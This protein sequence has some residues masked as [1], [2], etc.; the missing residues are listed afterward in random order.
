MINLR[1]L[2]ILGVFLVNAGFLHAQTPPRAGR[3]TQYQTGTDPC[4]DL[5]GD[6][7]FACVVANNSATGGGSASGG[8]VFVKVNC[9]QK[10]PGDLYA[11]CVCE[12]DNTYNET[13]INCKTE[14]CM[15]AAAIL[16]TS[17]VAK[18]SIKYD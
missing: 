6:E 16:R 14:A 7:Y 15:G 11:Q 17:C 8:N 9:P 18:C 3:G 10:Y 5:K 4:A 12:C 1:S 2:L 13:M